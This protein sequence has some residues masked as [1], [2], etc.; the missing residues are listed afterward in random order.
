MKVEGS[1]R[2]PFDGARKLTQSSRTHQCEQDAE[3][4]QDLGYEQVP[5]L[6]V[7]VTIQ[8]VVFDPVQLLLLIG[9]VTNLFL[10]CL[11]KL[12]PLT[13]LEQYTHTCKM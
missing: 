11:H 7:L 4:S 10:D 2:V 3:C 13:L 1:I 12:R 5:R 6:D 8:N 9:I